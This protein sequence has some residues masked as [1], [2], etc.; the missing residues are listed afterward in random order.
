[1]PRLAVFI[2]GFNVYHSIAENPALRP[3]R[4]LNYAKLAEQ[5]HVPSRDMVV[6][7]LW[8]T[9]YAFWDPAKKAR[10]EILVRANE[11]KGV[12]VILGNFKMQSRKCRK[13]HREV[14]SPVE[15]MTDINIASTMFEMACRNEYDKA[16]LISG[17]SDLVPAIRAVK[18]CY[19]SK[20]IGVAF[21]LKRFSTELQREATFCLWIKTK[22]LLRAQLEDAVLL[23]DGSS[24]NRPLNW[25][26]PVIAAC[27]TPPCERNTV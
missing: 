18:S 16:L 5:Y 7:V 8:F 14:I 26:D 9:S 27:G 3:A 17:D 1:M 23:P 25:Q 20:R 4:W 12:K 15:K 11:S 22:H 6:D 19:P 2:D 13:C 24:V 10:H 21:P